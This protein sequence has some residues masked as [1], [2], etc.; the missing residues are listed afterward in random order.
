M[1]IYFTPPSSPQNPPCDGGSSNLWTK[2]KEARGKHSGT[3]INPFDAEQNIGFASSMLGICRDMHANKH[4]SPGSSSPPVLLLN[5][6]L[7]SSLGPMVCSNG[8]DCIALKAG[9]GW[10]M[11]FCKCDFVRKD[12]FMSM[13]FVPQ[14]LDKCICLNC[15]MLSLLMTDFQL[16]LCKECLSMHCATST[17]ATASRQPSIHQIAKAM[18]SVRCNQA[19]A[20]KLL[21]ST[22]VWNLLQFVHERPDINIAGTGLELMRDA[23]RNVFEPAGG[24]LTLGVP[25][26]PNDIMVMEERERYFYPVLR[27]FL[28]PS[29]L[30]PQVYLEDFNYW[31]WFIGFHMP[32]A[33]QHGA[34]MTRQDFILAKACNMVGLF[35]PAVQEDEGIILQAT[36]T[37]RKMEEQAQEENVVP[38]TAVVRTF[39]SVLLQPPPQ[40]KQQQREEQ[41]EVPTHKRPKKKDLK[42]LQ[43]VLMELPASPSLDWE[44]PGV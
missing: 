9:T 3:V 23:M 8:E 34:Q 14:C 35:T 16:V 37:K 5:D 4:K 20:H 36:A 24:L 41:Q 39:S 28:G 2:M 18:D 15:G 22:H 10:C 32:V 27:K 42:D 33:F 29:P 7:S 12:I 17:S 13:E 11:G 30:A 6:R 38:Q 31:A 1:E 26:I 19:Y 44:L 43:L 25:S 21:A 40:K